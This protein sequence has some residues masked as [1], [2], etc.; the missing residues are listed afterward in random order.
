MTN[1]G[2]RLPPTLTG[3]DPHPSELSAGMRVVDLT[4]AIQTSAM[5]LKRL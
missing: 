1:A 2:V 5:L 3:D 4:V